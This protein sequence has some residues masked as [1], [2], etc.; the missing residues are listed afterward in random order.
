MRNQATQIETPRLY[1]RLSDFFNT[2]CKLTRMRKG[3]KKA[4]QSDSDV[5]RTNCWILDDK[6]DH[7]FAVKISR[8]EDVFALKVAIK[9]Q[10]PNTLKD[11]EPFLLI[12]YK[13]SIPCTPQLPE[14]ITALE[15][16]K[17]KLN[18]LLKLSKVLKDGL[19]DEVVHVVV[20]IPSGVWVYIVLS[21]LHL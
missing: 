1:L 7:V 4:T 19:I 3:K 12:L 16:D 5:F 2:V 10:M 6:Y 17:L 20:E 13:I 15:L 9:A 18:L 14:C 21:L 8:N 11:I